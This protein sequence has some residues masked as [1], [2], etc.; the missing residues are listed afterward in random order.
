MDCFATLAMTL[1]LRV[2]AACK[3]LRFFLLPLWEKVARTKS[4]TDEG[5]LSACAVPAGFG[6]RRVRCPRRQPLTRLRCCA[7]I[8]DAKHRR[9]VE[10]RRPKAAYAPSPTRGEGKK[11]ALRLL[12]QRQPH[13]VIRRDH[14]RRQALPQH[15]V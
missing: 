1:R 7:S 6:I 10:E 11:S 3:R 2:L 12:L 9:S 8:A 15:L 13:A 14:P 5:S 4:A